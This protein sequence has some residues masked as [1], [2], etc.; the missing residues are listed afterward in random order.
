M[1]EIAAREKR[2]NDVWAAKSST[3]TLSQNKIT[4]VSPENFPVLQEWIRY[5]LI[6]RMLRLLRLLTYIDRYRAVVNTFLKLIPAMGPLFGVLFGFLSLFTRWGVHSRLPSF[7][8]LFQIS[9]LLTLLL[10]YI[11]L[12]VVTF[13]GHLPGILSSIAWAFVS[14]AISTLA[15]RFHRACFSFDVCKCRSPFLSRL[16]PL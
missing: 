1:A 15:C 5:L 10:P 9:H 8:I 3:V 13:C 6:A 11:T 4:L 12:F 7:C 2:R 14:C 16:L